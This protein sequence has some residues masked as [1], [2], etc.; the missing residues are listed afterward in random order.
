MN[1]K[2]NIPTI[3]AAVSLSV[4]LVGDKLLDAVVSAFTEDGLTQSDFLLLLW[5]LTFG[6]FIVWVLQNGLK[7]L[8]TRFSRRQ[9]VTDG[10]A[11]KRQTLKA[12]RKEMKS[13]L[14]AFKSKKVNFDRGIIS[15]ANQVRALN[16]RDKA[17][18]AQKEK[19]ASTVISLKSSYDESFEDLE[20]RINKL[21]S[22]L[23]EAGN[24]LDE[25][26][27]WAKKAAAKHF[28]PPS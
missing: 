11:D 7:K 1:L 6:A 21:D 2:K 16:A 12:F 23:A 5:W 3:L 18:S 26:D 20:R 13:S 17:F 22:N 8:A 27:E 14:N 4:P 9:I 19:A 25:V 10:T 24:I 28:T 15:V